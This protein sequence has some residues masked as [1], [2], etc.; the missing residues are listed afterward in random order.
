VKGT[1]CTP[2]GCVGNPYVVFVLRS[3]LSLL[4]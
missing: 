2:N 1:Q 4:M 3:N